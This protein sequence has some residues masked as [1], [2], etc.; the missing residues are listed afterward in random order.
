MANSVAINIANITAPIMIFLFMIILI[1]EYIYFCNNDSFRKYYN[2]F[3][4]N[5]EYRHGTG[6]HNDY[7]VPCSI[8]HEIERFLL[9]NQCLA[10]Y[11][12]QLS[13]TFIYWYCTIGTYL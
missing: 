12:I 8:S 9:S 1:H 3:L 6:K 13:Y 4:N 10:S 2:M 5:F 11:C 7:G